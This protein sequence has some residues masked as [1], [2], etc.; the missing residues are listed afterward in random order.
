MWNASNCAVTLSNTANSFSGGITVTGG[1]EGQG[2]YGTNQQGWLISG[3]IG[4]P[5]GSTTGSVTLQNAQWDVN[6]VANAAGSLSKGTLTVD[7]G[8]T[9]Q[10]NS[11]AGNTTGTTSLTVLSLTRTNN[12]TLSVVGRRVS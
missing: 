2:G 11:G 1:F 5:L 9:L 3:A 10:V 12:A 4:H 8:N 6:G 7:G